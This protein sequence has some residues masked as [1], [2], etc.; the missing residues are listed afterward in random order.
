MAA[1]LKIA[2]EILFSEEQLL[3]EFNRR[4]RDAASRGLD[5]RN[6]AAFALVA[7]QEIPVVSRKCLD[8]TYVFTPYMETLKVKDHRSLPRRIGVPAIRDR[9]VLAQLNKLLRLAFPVESKSPLAS[10]YVRQLAKELQGVPIAGNWTAGCDIKRFYDSL[11]RG[12]LFRI[13]QKKLD[14]HVAFTLIAAAVN[15]PI[16]PATYRKNNVS[17]YV[18]QKGVPQGLAIS[19]A[20]AAIYLHEVDQA[21][22]GLPVSYYRFV[23]DVLVIGGREETKKAQRSFAAR[24][25]ARGLSV[26]KLGDKKNHHSALSTPFHYLGYSFSMP[27]VTVR[28][29]TIERLIHSLAGK[30]S[31]YKHNHLRVVER[32]EYL[33]E[34]LYQKVFLEELNERI[35]G[36][37]SMDKKYGWVAYF[38]EINDLSVLHRIDMIVAGLLRRV[39]ELRQFSGKTKKFSRAYFEM[40]HR[41]YGGY[42]RNYDEIQTPAQ[43]IKF[44]A[45]R[46]R[47]GP[48]ARLTE[49][50]IRSRFEMYRDRQ[51]GLMLADE[52]QT[53]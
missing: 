4:H 50:Q 52:V 13:L 48:G 25:R 3:S 21:M 33:T 53:Y 45:F 44:L 28:E 29:A 14:G 40:K 7:H 38:S 23:D 26:H 17:R 35:S 41:P 16:V 47:I 1:D 10:T 42:V 51:L 9:I 24:V 22:Q 30:I 5:R 27:K 46:G 49:E 36:A 11:D 32:K 31:D 2:S 43:M 39:P 18:E 6:G 12:R 15:T 8:A 20:L 37:I 34:E 19:N